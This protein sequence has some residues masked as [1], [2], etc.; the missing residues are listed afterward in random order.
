MHKMRPQW[1]RQE[2][3]LNHSNKID[4]QGQQQMPQQPP[5]QQVVPPI[6]Q[7]PPQTVLPAL[8]A[9]NWSYFKPEFRVKL[10]ENTEAHMFRT[11]M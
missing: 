9:M 6:P 8:M 2:N 5:Q 7:V 4:R 11:T 1:I 3:H 10:E